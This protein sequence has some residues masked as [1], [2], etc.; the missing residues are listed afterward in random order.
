MSRQK[1]SN[2]KFSLEGHPLQNF[3]RNMWDIGYDAVV[4]GHIHYPYI[5]NNNKKYFAIVGDWIDNFSYIQITKNSISL[6]YFN[7]KDNK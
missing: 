7:Q 3:A 6:N 2:R 4:L 5:E 1:S